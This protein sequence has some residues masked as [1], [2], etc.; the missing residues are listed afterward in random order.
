MVTSSQHFAHTESIFKRMEIQNL[1]DMYDLCILNFLYKVF[2]YDVLIHFLQYMDA[3]NTCKTYKLR[4]NTIR[5]P[6]HIHLFADKKFIF[7]SIL[8]KNCSSNIH[9]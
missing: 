9:S 2:H 8:F 5:T 1:F 4:K 6:V 3:F 7:G